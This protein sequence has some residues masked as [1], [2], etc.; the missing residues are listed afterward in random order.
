[1]R[2]LDVTDNLSIFDRTQAQQNH[3]SHPK[4]VD[5]SNVKQENISDL[6]DSSDDSSSVI[7]DIILPNQSANKSRHSPGKRKTENNA[8][9]KR[10]RKN[11]V[12]GKSIVKQES[13]YTQEYTTTQEIID[14][15]D[16]A[17]VSSDVILPIKSA[18]RKRKN[19]A[20]S[21]KKNKVTSQNETDVPLRQGRWLKAEEKIL[22]QNADSFLQ[23]WGLNE[24]SEALKLPFADRSQFFKA[25]GNGINREHEHIWR[26]CVRVFDP[27]NNLGKYTEEE[28]K[29]LAV[30]YDK[31]KDEENLWVLI[32]R[33]LGRSNG[34]VRD[35]MV[36]HDFDKNK[37]TEKVRKTWTQEET[38]LLSEAMEKY[39]VSNDS[40][41]KTQWSLV[42]S[43]VK[44]KKARECMYKWHQNNNSEAVKSFTTEQEIMLMEEV[45]KSKA[46]H[47]SDIDWYEIAQRWPHPID[48][49]VLRRRFFKVARRYVTTVLLADM[50]HHELMEILMNDFVK[51]ARREADRIAQI[52]AQ[53]LCAGG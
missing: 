6:S 29:K 52:K 2:S 11:D 5:E 31:Y 39:K 27:L 1:M 22:R 12:S 23:Q 8:T 19:K 53:G 38:R 48:L 47:Y 51:I 43:H 13:T 33:E 21:S 15:S 44:T 10:K 45:N 32:G 36:F 24:Y 25:C 41:C 35:K 49:R 9:K 34:S 46:N 4:Q 28:L 40:G 18:P 17:S 16:D 37:F 3:I 42:A 50:S 30:L 14:S 7:S 26:K 20:V